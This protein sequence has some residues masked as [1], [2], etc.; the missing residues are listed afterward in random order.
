MA[1]VRRERKGR[2]E[3]RKNYLCVNPSLPMHLSPPHTVSP[4]S[5][6]LYSSFPIYTVCLSIHC[7]SVQQPPSNLH[8]EGKQADR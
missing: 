6:L 3:A 8:Q 4:L 7:L 1:A 2:R 5:L